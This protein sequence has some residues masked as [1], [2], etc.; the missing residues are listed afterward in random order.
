MNEIMTQKVEDA[1]LE[2]FRPVNQ[3]LRKL[4]YANIVLSRGKECWG[5]RGPGDEVTYPKSHRELVP[6]PILDSLPFYPPSSTYLQYAFFAQKFVLI[7]ISCV[8]AP[9]C[10]LFIDFEDLAGCGFCRHHSFI[11]SLTLHPAAI[12]EY[13]LGIK[14]CG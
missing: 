6:A 7:H 4:F 14:P 9:K 10:L 3:Y 8:F 2:L 11:H 5:K 13:L 1:N 12:G